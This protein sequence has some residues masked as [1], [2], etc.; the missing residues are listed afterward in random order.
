M[1]TQDLVYFEAASEAYKRI[2]GIENVPGHRTPEG[3]FFQYGYYQYGVPS[4][5][6]LGW[7]V[8]ST[9]GGGA[10]RARPTAEPVAAAAPTGFHDIRR[11]TF[12]IQML[13]LS[14]M[15]TLII[16]S[17]YHPFSIKYFNGPFANIFGQHIIF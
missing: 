4:F 8:P 12:P 14:E 11:K 3:A 1:A 17:G 16:M 7:G 13:D 15:I 6:T 9:G 10:Q 2:T 5:S